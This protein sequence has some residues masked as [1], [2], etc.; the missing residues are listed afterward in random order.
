MA[1]RL[2]AIAESMVGMIRLIDATKAWGWHIMATTLIV[3]SRSYAVSAIAPSAPLTTPDVSPRLAQQ[4]ECR[5]VIIRGGAP[6]FPT[7]PQRP[8]TASDVLPLGSRVGMDVTTLPIRAP[9]GQ[10]YRFVTSPFNSSSTTAGYI[11]VRFV[12]RDGVFKETL[13]PCRRRMW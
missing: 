13:G 4:I 1:K 2:A 6:F 12:D 3:C 8:T 11:P 7:L 5:Q 9:D 10:S